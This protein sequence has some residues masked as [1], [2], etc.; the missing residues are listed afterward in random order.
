MQSLILVFYLLLFIVWISGMYIIA[1]LVVI[2][3]II[4]N[5]KST[6]IYKGTN[7]GN[8]KNDR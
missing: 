4:I 3:S 7:N 1:T 2:I 6:I 8:T 5:K